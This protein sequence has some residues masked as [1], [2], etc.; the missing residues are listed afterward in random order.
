MV[1]LNDLMLYGDVLA[2]E[3]EDVQRFGGRSN[4]RHYQTRV[5][6]LPA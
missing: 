1:T 3:D 4:L 6:Q 5:N 2:D